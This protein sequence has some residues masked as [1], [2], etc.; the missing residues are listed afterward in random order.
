[1]ARA[2]GGRSWLGVTLGLTLKTLAIAAMIALPVLGV[3]VASSLAALRHGPV[4]L[5]LL[6]GLFACPVLP[7]SWELWSAWRRS[8]RAKAAARILALSD[9]LILRTL[10]LNVVFLSALLATKPSAAFTALSARGDWMLD[11]RHDT[12]T[13]SARAALFAAAAKL[14]WLYLAA[15]DNPFKKATPEPEPQPTRSRIPP[16]GSSPS[17]TSLPTPSST[18]VPTPAPSEQVN[19]PSA[20]QA[21]SWPVGKELD[22]NVAA[23]PAS[24]ETTIQGVADYIRQRVPAPFARLKAVHDW[25]ADRVA[26]DAASYLA[27]SIPA[28]DAATVFRTRTSVCAGY[29][30]LLE[31]LGRAA[32]LEV[33]YLTGDA[34]TLGNDLN[35]QSHAWNAARID[36]KWY[37]IDATWDSGVLDGSHFRKRYSTEYFLTPPRVFNV[38]HLPDDAKWQLLA[39]PLSRGEFLRQPALTP[40]FFARGLQLVSPDRSQ[41]D[42]RGSLE[43]QLG[44]PEHVFLLATYEPRDNP[45]VDADCDVD[46]GDAPHIVCRFARPGRYDVKLYS[47]REANGTFEFTGQLQANAN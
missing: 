36:G 1:M 38:D 20:P 7:V 24:A 11:G 22:P 41:V 27:R 23:M 47:N 46:N 14:E 35:G 3:W 12:W 6:A 13:R 8:K 40:L 28:Q 30:N 19:A 43:I 18:P 9:R 2:V 44:N 4:W 33:L 16:P 26:Y 39:Q 17:S 32:G 42:V 5:A 25:V 31:A 34:R 21:P 29:A 10:A 15:H 37:L 45:G